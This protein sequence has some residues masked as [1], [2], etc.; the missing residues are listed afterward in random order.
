MEC[1]L[2]GTNACG[3]STLMKSIGLTLIMAQAGFLFHVKNLFIHL[4]LKY[5]QGF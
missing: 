4:I 1:L 2:Y 3:K 5:L